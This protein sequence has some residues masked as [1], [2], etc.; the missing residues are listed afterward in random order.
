MYPM[1]DQHFWFY[2]FYSFIGIRVTKINSL[3]NP[4]LDHNFQKITL[5]QNSHFPW[6][7]RWNIVLVFLTTCGR[8]F[9]VSFCRFLV[10]F[11]SN[12]CIL[13][14][15]ET[16]FFL[17]YT[18]SFVFYLL[19]GNERLPLMIIISKSLA[20]EPDLSS[21][22]QGICPTF[23]RESPPGCWEAPQVL[24]WNLL[25]FLL[26]PWRKLSPSPLWDNRD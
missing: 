21:V 11:L 4:N 3:F 10:L 6:P 18:P 1:P 23:S 8:S 5:S 13:V 22:L 26:D 7:S 17:L 16:H 25:Y 20:L 15:P 12:T 14:S 24:K 19:L 2:Y 9:S